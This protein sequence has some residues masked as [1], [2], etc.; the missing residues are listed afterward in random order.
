M[1]LRLTGNN[2]MNTQLK[3]VPTA[4]PTVATAT[5]SLLDMVNQ[6]PI[7]STR[8]NSLAG[9][10]VNLEKLDHCSHYPELLKTF[11]EL[12]IKMDNLILTTSDDKEENKKL[13]D[14]YNYD[15]VELLVQA[16]LT[17]E[18]SFYILKGFLI[19]CYTSDKI[20]NRSFGQYDE[21][22]VKTWL[23]YLGIVNNLTKAQVGLLSRSSCYQSAKE[24]DRCF[25]S[26]K[27]TPNLDL[28]P[29]TLG[30]MQHQHKY[31]TQPS[32]IKRPETKLIDL[33]IWS[34]SGEKEENYDHIM[35]WLAWSFFHPEDN[36]LLPALNIFG[37]EGTGKGLVSEQLMSTIACNS[38]IAKINLSN[39]N[40]QVEGSGYC[41]LDEVQSTAKD[42]ATVKQ[43][44]G[45]KL[46]RL[47][48]KSIDAFMIEASACFFM[49]TNSSFAS[50]FL[51]RNPKENRRFS[52]INCAQKNGGLNGTIA[53]HYE[54]INTAEEIEEVKKQIV[55]AINDR[56]IVASW[57]YELKEKHL[58]TNRPQAHH[59]EDYKVLMDVQSD[60]VEVVMNAMLERSSTLPLSV[61]K[62]VLSEVIKTTNNKHN[63]DKT[64]NM[65]I[66]NYA[67]QLG[68]IAHDHNQK[69]GS[70][71][72]L[73]YKNLVNVSSR[74]V[75]YSMSEGND[76]EFDI[77]CFYEQSGFNGDEYII[78]KDLIVDI[79]DSL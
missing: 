55:A 27:T 22:P 1:A 6:Q 56:F 58:G 30:K 61:V 49:F 53:D 45:A 52:I 74:V 2:I 77:H 29:S 64:N 5:I 62:E 40:S 37:A 73:V 13:L 54:N 23:E 48:K 3:L 60:M 50:A 68:M 14:K 26:S 11:N 33:L 63:A 16:T 71:N 24:L 8:T 41:I 4:E 57:L 44:I 18:D 9:L 67:I 76:P 35:K 72:R 43:L 17:S 46:T 10:R 36:Y 69:S 70:D 21:T 20:E 66:K 34:L 42:Q 32:E 78:S 25:K 59:G 79:T 65:K 15:L 47:E 51:G 38:S 31:R 28:D 39:F 7:K 19:I 12:E 75:G